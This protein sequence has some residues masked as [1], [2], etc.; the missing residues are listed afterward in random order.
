MGSDSKD[1]GAAG[2]AAAETVRAFFAHLQSGEVEEAKKLVAGDAEEMTL[3]APGP[4]ETL[5]F[6][7]GEVE[8]E[9]DTFVVPVELTF[10][11]PD[12]SGT[13]SMAL[14][15]VPTEEGMRVDFDLTMQKMMGVSPDDLMEG[16]KEGMEGLVDGIQESVEGLVGGIRGGAER[17]RGR[18]GEG[19][20]V[21][22]RPPGKEV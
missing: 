5:S 16:L 14:V 18:A 15:C 6:T 7:L 20:R 3:Q 2:Q 17:G 4:G 8:P 11:S 13:E 22:P 19:D 12:E 1:S 10:E 9:D 21:D